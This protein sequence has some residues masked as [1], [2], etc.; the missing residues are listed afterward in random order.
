MIVVRPLTQRSGLLRTHSETNILT[1]LHVD[2]RFYVPKWVKS[3]GS[4]ND[5]RQVIACPQYRPIELCH[6]EY[7]EC[8]AG[9][10]KDLSH[11]DLH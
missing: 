2:S 1:V 7:I 6:V 5:Q 9:H 3:A 11:V 8:I 10:L 4:D